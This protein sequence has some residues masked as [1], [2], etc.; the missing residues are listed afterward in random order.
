MCTLFDIDLELEWSSIPLS[1]PTLKTTS[2][3][4]FILHSGVG[5]VATAHALFSDCKSNC[6]QTLNPNFADYSQFFVLRSE[7][8]K[9][10]Q[11][12]SVDGSSSTRLHGTRSI[13][14][15]KQKS[16]FVGSALS[17]GDLAIGCID[18]RNLMCPASPNNNHHCKRCCGCGPPLHRSNFGRSTCNSSCQNHEVE[19]CMHAHEAVNGEVVLSDAATL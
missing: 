11:F 9:L 18:W 6:S 2:S 1:C 19:P 10:I 7:V 13:I 15:E 4:V 14:S 17:R 12:S 5:N 8:I 16:G 3:S